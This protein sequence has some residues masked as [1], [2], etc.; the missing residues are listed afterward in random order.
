MTG[1]APL[2]QALIAKVAKRTGISEKSVRE[3]ISR[4]GSSQGIASAAALVVWAR[5]LGIGTAQALKRL[6]P[7][8]QEQVQATV[9]SSFTEPVGMSSVRKGT[10]AR[11]K[12]ANTDPL[13]AAV[14][15]LISDNQL[16]S[17]CRNLFRDRKHFDRIMREATTVLEHRLKKLAGIKRMNPE[18]LVNRVLN[19]DPSKAILVIS[20]DPGEQAGFHSICRGLMLAFRNTAHHEL[21]DK[22]TREDALRFCGFVDTILTF[23]ENA[24]VNDPS[25]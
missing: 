17:R 14:D 25:P 6:E 7:H 13:L 24:E 23:I 16:R 1:R 21:D 3:R 10:K 19:P 20:H 9:I 8:Q 11:R 15:F 22:V 5:D 4:N 12:T 18:R 2:D